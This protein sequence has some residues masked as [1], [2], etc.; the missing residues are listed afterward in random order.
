MKEIMSF[1][2]KTYN[3]Q[4]IADLARLAWPLFVVSLESDDIL[5]RSWI[6]ERFN[7]LKSH[8]A[9]YRRAHQ[10]ILI[11]LADCLLDERTMGYFELFRCK[12]VQCF[13]L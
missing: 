10:A 4:G 1:G 13:L 12:S 5:H 7:Q 11:S 2:F 3:T 6:L 9:N 8:G